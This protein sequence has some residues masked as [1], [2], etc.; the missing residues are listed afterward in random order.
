MPSP[1]NNPHEL[2]ARQRLFAE[3]YVSEAFFGNGVQTYIEVYKPNQSKKGWYNVACAGA[4]EIL[5]NR[6]VKLYVDS[7]LSK[8]KEQRKKGSH[9]VYIINQKGSSYYKIGW[10]SVGVE[11]K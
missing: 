9:G 3:T 8:I 2:N 6:K 7:L 4:S 5:S 1:K 10:T 11:S